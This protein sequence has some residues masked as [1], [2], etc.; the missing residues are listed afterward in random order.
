MRKRCLS[1]NSLSRLGFLLTCSLFFRF[2]GWDFFHNGFANP[3]IVHSRPS[4]FWLNQFHFSASGFLFTCCILNLISFY[5]FDLI[6]I[7]G[8]PSSLIVPTRSGLLFNQ[9][10]FFEL[11]V[12]TCPAM[13][14]LFIQFWPIDIFIIEKCEWYH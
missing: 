7:N 14:F 9:W 6:F 1:K 11:Y 8:F 3:F 13:F 2:F 5:F 12:R 10:K 4:F